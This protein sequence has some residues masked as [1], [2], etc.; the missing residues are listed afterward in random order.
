MIVIVVVI[1]VKKSKVSAV[2][3]NSM[4]EDNTMGVNNKD[5]VEFGTK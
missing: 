2:T 3:S 4:V 5:M 1:C